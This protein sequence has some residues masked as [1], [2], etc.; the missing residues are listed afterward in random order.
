MGTSGDA[1]GGEV[2][3]GDGG[4]VIDDETGIRTVDVGHV[5]VDG[6]TVL[7]ETH[8]AGADLVPV[9]VKR[10]CFDLDDAFAGVVVGFGIRRQKPSASECVRVERA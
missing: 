7:Q 5:E 4:A 3:E 8:R 10:R 6:G 1:D 2:F 9:R